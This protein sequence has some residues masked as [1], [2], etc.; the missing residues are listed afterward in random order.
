MV[1][2][3]IT[4]TLRAGLDLCLVKGFCRILSLLMF[5]QLGFVAI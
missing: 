2:V 5:L 4:C 1:C 3:C